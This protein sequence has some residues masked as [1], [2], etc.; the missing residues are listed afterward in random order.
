MTY[1]LQEDPLAFHRLEQQT[2]FSVPRI[3]A[4]K[5][6]GVHSWCDSVVQNEYMRG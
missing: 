1:K 4:S 3:I 6:T 2:L 5:D